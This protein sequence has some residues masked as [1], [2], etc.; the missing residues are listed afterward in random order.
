[1]PSLDRR[2]GSGVFEPEQLTSLRQLFEE[3]C[4][5]LGA[6]TDS[7]EADDIAL[8]VLTAFKSGYVDK[9]TMFAALLEARDKQT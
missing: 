6:S 4:T 9:E 5:L 2:I 3:A 1:M 8:K 7:A